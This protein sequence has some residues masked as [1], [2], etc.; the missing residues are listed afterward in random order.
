MQATTT[1]KTSA[2][3]L[4]LMVGLAMP[5]VASAQLP[6]PPGGGS[7]L[8]QVLETVDLPDD[9]RV[10]V[11]GLLDASRQKRRSLKRSLRAAH[12]EMRAL[13]NADAPEEAAILAQ[14]EKIGALQTDLEKDRLSTLL[15][16]RAQLSPDQRERMTEALQ[17]AGRGPRG[18]RPRPPHHRPPPRRHHGNGPRPDFSPPPPPFSPASPPNPPVR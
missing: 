16:I 2:L 17:S 12:D 4:G 8:E 11:D 7:R 13:L 3:I 6:G 18:G 10:R 14:A 1:L 15:R 9:V 5:V